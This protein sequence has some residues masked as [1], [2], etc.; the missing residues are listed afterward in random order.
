MPKSYAP[1]NLGFMYIL[2]TALKSSATGAVILLLEFAV[3][4]NMP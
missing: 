2:L 1:A 3:E 4:K